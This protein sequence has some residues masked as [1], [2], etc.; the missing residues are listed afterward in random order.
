MGK[1]F[2]DI[3]TEWTD[4]TEKNVKLILASRVVNE[5]TS[6]LNKILIT[7]KAGFIDGLII[8]LKKM[9]QIEEQE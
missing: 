9:L 4:V 3:V 5:T 2:S 7:E 6:D 1:R 8:M